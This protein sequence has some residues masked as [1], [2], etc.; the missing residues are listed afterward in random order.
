VQLAVEAA[1]T[2]RA[3][4]RRVRVVSMPS[5][6]VFDRQDAAY[7]ASVL[8][9]GVPR[10]AVEAGV[11][12]GWCRYTGCI[13]NVVGIDTFGASA[14]AKD[15]FKHFGIT[16]ERVAETALAAIGG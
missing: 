5:T 3:A 9:P 14:P 6:S 15:L 12:D 1:A 7:Q 13:G 4:G 8:P 2:L 10:V 11:R 16:A